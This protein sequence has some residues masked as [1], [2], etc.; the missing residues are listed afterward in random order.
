L[1]RAHR[2]ATVETWRLSAA[3]RYAAIRLPA[4]N[5]ARRKAVEFAFQYVG[6]P[7]IYAG[8]WHRPTPSGYCCGAQPQGG[9]DCSGFVW[10]VVRAPGGGWD[11]TSYRPYAGWPLPERSSR[12]MARATPERRGWSRMRPMDVM[13]FDPS[14]GTGWRGVS[15]A[16]LW[17]GNGWLIDSAGGQGGV[18]INWGPGSW[19]RDS[20]VWAR[21]VLG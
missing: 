11:N 20:F 6:Y 7:Y 4:M 5:E 14:G 1:R 9:F 12:D 21:R 13:F 17:L 10:W 18:T 16:A 15:H 19:Y 3:Q 2:V 8:E